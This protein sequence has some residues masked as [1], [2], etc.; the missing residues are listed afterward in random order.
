MPK[1]RLLQVIPFFRTFCVAL[2][3]NEREGHN[4]CDIVF[5]LVSFVFLLPTKSLI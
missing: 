1:H 4:S 2:S 3:V 5:G